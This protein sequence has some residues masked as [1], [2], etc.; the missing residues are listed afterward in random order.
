MLYICI[1]NR[2]KFIYTTGGPAVSHLIGVSL[3]FFK[4]NIISELQDPL[5]GKD[6]GRYN[7]VKFLR[8]LEI[9]L[10]KFCWKLVYVTKKSFEESLD[11][12]HKENLTYIY[13]SS[14]KYHSLKNNFNSLFESPFASAEGLF[15]CF[16]FRLFIV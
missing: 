16:M 12:F 14:R 6:I 2:I 8:I 11:R 10:A 4:I 7:S 5:Y 1:I 13:P 9:I 3:F 15:F